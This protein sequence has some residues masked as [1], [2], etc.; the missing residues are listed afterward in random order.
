MIENYRLI[1]EEYLKDINS[2][3]K[4]YEH[5]KSGAKV[6]ALENNDNKD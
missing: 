3:A 1:K 5:I 4:I 2:N 6:L